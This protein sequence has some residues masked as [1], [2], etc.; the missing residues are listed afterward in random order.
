MGT[1]ASSENKKEA[2]P[3]C[4]WQPTMPGLSAE[5]LSWPGAEVHLWR[6]SFSDWRSQ[7]DRLSLSL[8]DWERERML[9]FRDLELAARY[10]IG[11]GVLRELLGKYLEAAPAGIE[12]KTN[13]QGKPELAAVG[14]TPLYFNM[15]HSEDVILF[16]F[17]GSCPLGVDV[18]A[19]RPGPVSTL[20]VR[21]ILYAEE[22]DAWQTLQAED[23][24]P[25][26]YQT[27]AR[28]E[29]VLK[30]LGVGLSIEPDTFS[31]GLAKQPQVVHVQ[32]KNIHLRD[33]AVKASVK[34]AI[35]LTEGEM[36]RQRCFIATT[37]NY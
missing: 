30:A 11:H 32:G 3:D 35:A 27:W 14:E 15:A 18:E 37:S 12:I 33:L 19:I 29:A 10:A 7:A 2:G 13:A 26:F 1:I 17:T 25:V 24:V 21:R 36:P 5:D 22:W 23:Q 16:G 9:R 4:S 20:E 34:A 8:C 6:V 28:K 31:V